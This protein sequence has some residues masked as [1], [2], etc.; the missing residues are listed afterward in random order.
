MNGCC[1]AGKKTKYRH[2]QRVRLD[3]PLYRWFC[4]YHRKLT[5]VAY[6]AYTVKLY[7]K[8][9]LCRHLNCWSLRCSWSI[10]CRRCSNYIFILNWTHGFNRLGKDNCKTRGETFKFWDSGCL[11]WDTL[12]YIVV[13]LTHFSASASTS[14]RHWASTLISIIQLMAVR[15]LSYSGLIGHY[16]GCWCL[17]SSTLNR[18]LE[19]FSRR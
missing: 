5:G 8:T 9:Y 3:G 14:R 6:C 2:L 10:A 15:G 18:P 12:R 4:I 19:Y 11:I 17:G 16:H 7:Y 13:L 1:Y